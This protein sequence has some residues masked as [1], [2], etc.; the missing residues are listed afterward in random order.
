MLPRFQ[1]VLRRFCLAIYRCNL[2]GG[3]RPCQEAS[4]EVGDKLW[5]IPDAASYKIVD[6][7]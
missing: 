5:L 3:N 6:D 4:V 7:F 1:N 2:L